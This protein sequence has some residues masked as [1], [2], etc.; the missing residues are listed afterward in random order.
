MAKAAKKVVESEL[1]S[2]LGETIEQLEEKKAAGEKAI[3]ALCKTTKPTELF[4]AAAQY[5]LVVRRWKRLSRKIR[6][7]DDE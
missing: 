5:G 7:S 2:G 3:L 6:K 4:E 1:V